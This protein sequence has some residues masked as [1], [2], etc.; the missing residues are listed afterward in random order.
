MVGPGT[1]LH[2]LSLIVIDM[3]EDLSFAEGKALNERLMP[4]LS[5]GREP[6]REDPAEYIMYDLW[7]EMHS[8]DSELAQAV[9]E[10]TFQFMRAQT[11]K[12]RLTQRCIGQYLQYR[13][14]DV[15]KA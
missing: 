4:L 13:Q 1:F 5:G 8:C 11:D 7:K 9:I 3:L 2:A 14:S 6:D 10:P 15:G 12:T